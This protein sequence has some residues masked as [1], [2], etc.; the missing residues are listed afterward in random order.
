M[1]R[2]ERFSVARTGVYDAFCS[3][4]PVDTHGSA[5]TLEKSKNGFI[6]DGFRCPAHFLPLAEIERVGLQ[7]C[8]TFEPRR[9]TQVR[10]QRPSKRERAHGA[11]RETRSGATR[12]AAAADKS[13]ASRFPE[14]VDGVPSARDGKRERR[15]AG[16]PDGT[17]RRSGRPDHPGAR[18]REGPETR[19]RGRAPEAWHASTDARRA[20]SSIPTETPDTSSSSARPRAPLPRSPL[21]RAPRADPSKTPILRGFRPR[22]RTRS[23]VPPPRELRFLRLSRRWSAPRTPRPSSWRQPT[24]RRRFQCAAASV[25]F[26]STAIGDRSAP[27]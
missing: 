27:P 11:R 6:F 2:F 21:R 9:G 25:E 15:T 22:R 1:F 20:G 12:A 19:S 5:D 10:R 26:T 13:I 24:G 18:E 8:W 23:V 17:N 14:R 3:I 16:Y 4:V 7:A